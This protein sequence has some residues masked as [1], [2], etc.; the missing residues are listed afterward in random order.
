MPDQG[1]VYAVEIVNATGAWE[2]YRAF[3]GGT[4]ALD[5]DRC[6][7]RLLAMHP[8]GRARVVRKQIIVRT[9]DEP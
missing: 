9:E 7:E 1:V 5:A 4:A 2:E 8:V 3:A 6:Y